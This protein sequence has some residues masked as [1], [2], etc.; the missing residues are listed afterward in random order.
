[1]R[2]LFAVVV[3]SLLEGLLATF[4][5]IQVGYTILLTSI[6]L[7]YFV[8]KAIFKD[9]PTK[10][11]EASEDRKVAVDSNSNPAPRKTKVWKVLGIAIL[12]FYFVFFLY[13]DIHNGFFTIL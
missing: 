6:I 10:T 5:G 2:V 1:M 8:A 9:R 11:E 13:H 3:A 7:L 12:I 4:V